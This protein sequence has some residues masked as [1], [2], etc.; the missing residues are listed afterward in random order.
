MGNMLIFGMGY[1]AQVVAGRLRAQGWT[2]GGTG[3]TGDFAF[4]DRAA[5]QAALAE[6]THVLSSVPPLREGGDPVLQTYGA[7]I[8]NSGAKWIG[9]LSSTGVYGDAGGAWVDES[10]PVGN[11]R[12]SARTQADADWQALA[13][14]VRVFRLPG[15][16]GPGRSALDRVK[17]GK[18]HRIAIPDQVFSRVHVGDIASGVFAAFNGPPGVYNLADDQPCSQNAVIE[19]AARLLG[20][21]PPPMQSLEEAQLSPMALAFYAENR[22]VA[23][24]KAKRLLGWKPAF[25]TYREGLRALSAST[26][27]SIAS[28]DPATANTDQR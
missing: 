13:D 4:A 20:Q 3:S 25:P 23:N 7:A 10:A 24:G 15:I 11:G 14:Q 5:V 18:A 1:T 16:Y 8:A 9:Y 2:V 17:D 21:E 27:P 26:R 12:R 22:R 28:A 6:A 19:E